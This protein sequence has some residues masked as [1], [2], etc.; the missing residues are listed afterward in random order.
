MVVL[1]ALS[2]PSTRMRASFSPKIDSRRETQ[3]PIP[4]AYRGDQAMSAAAAPSSAGRLAARA[5]RPVQPGSRV[6]A[7]LECRQV[8]LYPL[9][10]SEQSKLGCSGLCTCWECLIRLVG[11]NAPKKFAVG[12]RYRR[13]NREHTVGARTSMSSVYGKHQRSSTG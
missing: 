3:S 7:E 11:L 10:H 9:P 1:P 2:R 8:C 5:H 4:A 12:Q 6:P 13:E